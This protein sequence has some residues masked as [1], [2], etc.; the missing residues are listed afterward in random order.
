[1]HDYGTVGSGGAYLIMELVNGRAALERPGEIAPDRVADWFAQ[2]LDGVQ[3]AHGLGIVH[4]DLKPE[5]VMI[6]APKPDE[7]PRGEADVIK[8]WISDSPRSSTTAAVRPRQSPQP[9]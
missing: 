7:D 1:V 3:F 5:N 6:L 8:S 4:R 2:L 9:A